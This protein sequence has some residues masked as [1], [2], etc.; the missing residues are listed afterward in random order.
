MA[1]GGPGR[2]RTAARLA[3]EA[4]VTPVVTTTIDGALARAVA[5]HV[6]A[7]IPSVP[8]CGLATGD[9]LAEDLLDDDPAPVAAGQIEVPSDAGAAGRTRWHE[10]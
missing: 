5:V 7:A 6:A 4:G 3:L 1:L 2:A 9:R 10:D 8:A